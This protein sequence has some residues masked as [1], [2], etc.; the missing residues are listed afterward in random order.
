MG[1]PGF[2]CV[3][4]TAL[5]PTEVESEFSVLKM[6]VPLHVLEIGPFFFFFRYNAL[7]KDP[8]FSS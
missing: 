6:A 3:L 1:Y 7:I 8:A 4:V 2:N 5:A